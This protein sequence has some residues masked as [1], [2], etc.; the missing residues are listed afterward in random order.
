[1]TPL[2]D[3][4]ERL[5]S[6]LDRSESG[7]NFVFSTAMVYLPLDG[8][9]REE[10]LLADISAVLSGHTESSAVIREAVD[11][12]EEEAENRSAAGSEMSDYEREPRELAER[13]KTI[14]DPEWRSGETQ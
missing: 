12:L 2:K 13:L 5:L 9:D 8:D 3:A 4:R 6:V 7:C 11:F 10:A 1:M 14:V